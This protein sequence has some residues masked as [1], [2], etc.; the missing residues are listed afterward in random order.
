M[1]IALAGVIE[2]IPASSRAGPDRILTGGTPG[3]RTREHTMQ[4]LPVTGRIGGATQ[5]EDDAAR[6]LVALESHIFAG[7]G[8]DRAAIRYGERLRFALARVEELRQ[9]A[10]SLG[11]VFEPARL[12]IAIAIL[13]SHV[14]QAST[15]A[16]RVAGRTPRRSAKRDAPAQTKSDDVETEVTA[17]AR[18]AA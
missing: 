16:D 8:E 9:S 18:R 17:A 4:N 13:E 7:T 10:R 5:V 3:G 14:G 11:G 15:F 6:L 12:E 1:I 2:G